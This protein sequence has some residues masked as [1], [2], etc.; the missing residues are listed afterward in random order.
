MA[1]RVT[2]QERESQPSVTLHVESPADGFRPDSAA[3]GDVAAQNPSVSA[4]VA[5]ERVE[6]VG[7]RQPGISRAEQ[8]MSPAMLPQPSGSRQPIQKA[9][10]QQPGIIVR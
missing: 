2:F 4:P 1:E 7:L 6:A 9:G 10:L 8:P 3:A 5:V